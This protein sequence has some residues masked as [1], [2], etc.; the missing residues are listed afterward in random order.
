MAQTGFGNSNPSYEEHYEREIA[1]GTPSPSPAG[2]VFPALLRTGDTWV[3]LT[4]AG[5]DGSWHASRL[6][7]DSAGGVYRLGTPMAPEVFTDGALL[8]HAR[9]TLVSPW[10]VI[11]LGSLAT[12]MESTLGTDLAAPAI[13]FDGAKVVP[14]HASWSWALLKDDATVFDVQK[15]F[16]DYAA[17][18]GWDYTL[19]RCRVGP[20]HRLRQDGRAGR[21][22]G[23]ERHQAAGLVQTRRAAG[24]R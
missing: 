6:R 11:A 1:V 20:P 10:R 15:R 14:G 21:V 24:T 5:M 19:V 8:A 9:G 12:V 13:A 22:R 3:A 23:D 4:E 16:I 17:D 2:W 18:M 7:A